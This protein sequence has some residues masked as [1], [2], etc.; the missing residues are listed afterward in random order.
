MQKYCLE[1]GA[2]LERVQQERERLVCPRCGWVYYA[3][4]KI[5]AAAVI[6]VDGRLLL[7][8]RAY[9]PWRGYWYL[10]AGYVEVDESPAEAAEREVYE[11]TGLRV[12][13]QRL[14]DVRYFDD[15]PRGPGVLVIYACQIVA[16]ELRVSHETDGL[17]FFDAQ[18]LPDDL[19]G[20]GHRE[21]ILAWQYSKECCR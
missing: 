18:H 8:R 5:G 4:P 2:M 3:Q 20:A 12:Q 14:V 19:A 17:C 13:A 7:A 10:P 9:E 1:C 16:G 6:E 15:D 21:T 11:E